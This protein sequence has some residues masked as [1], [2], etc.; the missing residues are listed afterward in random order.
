M[1]YLHGS[2]W[3]SGDNPYTYRAIPFGQI[4]TLEIDQCLSMRL[5]DGSTISLPEEQWSIG[6]TGGEISAINYLESGWVHP[7][8]VP[9]TSIDGFTQCTA[10]TGMSETTAALATI[11]TILTVLGGIITVGFGMLGGMASMAAP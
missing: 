11:E 10:D 4:T 7:L 2:T 6:I 3:E 1:R 9:F 5:R 8:S